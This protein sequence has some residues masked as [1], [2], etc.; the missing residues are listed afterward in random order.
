MT[1]KQV[2]KPVSD[3][4]AENISFLNDFCGKPLP[5]GADKGTLKVTLT[6]YAS[7][8]AQIW[9]LQVLTNQIGGRLPA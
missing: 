9:Q 8:E 3:T 1:F 6:N 5:I 2:D 7:T 4:F